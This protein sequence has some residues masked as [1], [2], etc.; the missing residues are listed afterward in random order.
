MK[1]MKKLAKE[2]FT[3]LHEKIELFGDSIIATA[4][5]RTVLKSG[6]ILNQGKGDLLTTQTVLACGP[7]SLVKVGDKVEINP[8]RFNVKHIAP[9]NDIGPD[10]KEVQVP[11]E[12]I[13]GTPSLFIST[14]E[15][16]YKYKK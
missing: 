2:K 6:I 3:P 14:R 16:K 1:N 11:I 9:K 7:H 10:K 5:T 13:E 12:F 15:L 8:N 4:T